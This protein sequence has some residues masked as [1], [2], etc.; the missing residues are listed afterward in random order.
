M[1]LATAGIIG[2]QDRPVP[3]MALA[4]TGIIGGQAAVGWQKIG[5]T[6]VSRIG[7]T[8]IDVGWRAMHEHHTIHGVSVTW[9]LPGIV[10]SGGTEAKDSCSGQGQCHDLHLQPPFFDRPNRP[11]DQVFCAEVLR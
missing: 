4:T 6:G 7:I 3:V 1:A 10:R 2:D 9:I 8:L 5:A 11:C